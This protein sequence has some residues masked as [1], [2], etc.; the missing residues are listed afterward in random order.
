MYRVMAG[1]MGRLRAH[2]FPVTTYTYYKWLFASE[3]ITLGNRMLS[4]SPICHRTTAKQLALQK[5]WDAMLILNKG[6]KDSFVDCT[7]L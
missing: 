1:E 5:S 4:T 6:V 7:E 3:G 2:L